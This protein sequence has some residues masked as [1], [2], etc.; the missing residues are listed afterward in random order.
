MFTD[1]VPAPKNLRFSEVTQSSFRVTWEHGGPD[2]SLYRVGWVKRGET[3][4]QQVSG[5][6]CDQPGHV[7][8]MSVLKWVGTKTAA[9]EVL[10][11][12]EY[13]VSIGSDHQRV[14]LCPASIGYVTIMKLKMS[15]FEFKITLSFRREKISWTIHYGFTD[16]SKLPRLSENI[17][18]DHSNNNAPFVF[19]CLSFGPPKLFLGP[20]CTSAQKSVNEMKSVPGSNFKLWI[21]KLCKMAT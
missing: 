8:K 7:Y 11:M 3:D 9:E 18:F 19:H 5:W 2:V 13:R 16:S 21:M 17:Q 1:V 20:T 15:V 14:D 10:S 6:W 4:F 12:S